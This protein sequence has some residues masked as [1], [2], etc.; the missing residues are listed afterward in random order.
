MKQ[1][2]KCGYEILAFFLGVALGTMILYLYTV[3]PEDL[4]TR[5]TI[6]FGILFDVIALYFVMRK[7]WRTKWRYRVM[8][9]V[10]KI[11]D[12]LARVFKIFRQKLGLPEREDQTVL[13]GKSKIYFDSKPINT[14]TQKAKKP[15]AWKN[16]KNDKERLGYLYRYMIDSNIHRGLPVFSSETPSE[17]REK[18]EYKD[19]E[20]QIFDLYVENRYKDDIELDRD[21]LDD[22]KKEMKNAKE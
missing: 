6:L 14:Q 9:S 22:L 13:G 2:R 12:K 4:N 1:T 5:G 3:N 17:I 21:M 19:V 16:L 10:Q 7:L 20:N 15:S 18:K 8:P 11:L